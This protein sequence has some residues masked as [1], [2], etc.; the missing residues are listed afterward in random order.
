[1]MEQNGM[2]IRIGFHGAAR[3]VTGSCLEVESDGRRILLDCGLFQ[4]TRSIEAL[5]H[6]PLPFNPAA[7]DAVVL[8]HAHIDHSGLLPK[9]TAAGYEGPIWCT[10]ETSDLLRYM[11]ADAGRIQEY[12]AERRNRRRDR[13]G[14][15]PFEPIYTESDGEA[16]WRL[17]R[18]VERDTWFEPAEGI[19][20]CLRNA[21]H[22]LGATS[23]EL[24]AAGV[25][26]MYSGDIGPDNKAFLPDPEGATGFDHV[27]CE[28]TYGDRTRSRMSVQ[29]RR[30]LLAEEIRTALAKGGNLVIP[31][32]ALER[33][34]ELL[35]DIAILSE[36]GRIGGATVFVDSPLANRVTGVFRKYVRTLE[37]TGGRDVFAHPSIHYVHE[38]T[39]S[40]RLN[41]V[42]GAVI[43]AASGM[44]EA[45]RI[46]HHLF[47]NLARRDST[48][49]FVGFQAAGSLGRVILEGA[50]RVRISG[51]DVAVRAAV[52]S[53]DSYS[54]H[55]DQS[56][57]IQWIKD[58]GPIAG[59][60][61]LDHGEEASV[62]ALR[63]LANAEHLAPDVIVPEI[64]ERYELRPGAPAKRLRS[65]REDLH[66]VIGRD[67]QNDY[68][69]FATSLKQ[70]LLRLPDDAARRKAVVA[71]QRVL[72]Q[73]ADP[74]R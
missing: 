20:V 49:L 31:S 45:G 30:D 43:I 60:L 56:E 12:E 62:M 47:Y 54:A 15:V 70:Q 52:R 17:T 39:E 72:E 26:L 50:K 74:N 64:G 67:W 6:Q 9:L 5:N 16:A 23:I 38:S 34:Q 73:V 19:R 40:M 57:L 18:P 55:A 48:I 14:D 10:A 66:C 63:D 36:S 69:S 25:R 35:L 21:G 7:V 37:D 1:M 27:I 51:R 53:I 61:F 11:L 58:R 46:R 28:A 8:S 3:T 29:Q 2:A 24:E 42:S 41:R 32:F 33:T 44:C 13:A 68:A 65:G 22:I 4:G 71:L 59:T